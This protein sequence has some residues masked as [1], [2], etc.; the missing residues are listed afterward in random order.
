M[1]ILA[2]MQK[3]LLLIAVGIGAL[4]II[5]VAGFFLLNKSSQSN[6]EKTAVQDAQQE[7]SQ[8][9]SSIQKLL[10]AGKNETCSVKYPA[11]EQT[12][13]GT[14][15][16]NGKNLRGDFTTTS[17]GK[18]IDSHIIQDETYMYSWTSLAPQGT[19]MKIAELEKLQASPATESVDL[20]QEFDINC[21]S[22][23][24]DIGKFTPPA[25]VNFVEID[26]TPAQTQQPDKSI[27]DQITDPQAKTSCL[28]SL[29]RN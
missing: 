24:V 4:V 27:C 28:Q 7:Q 23:S 3:Q 17:E 5:G 18:T 22:W 26:T 16:V 1:C 6:K 20:N 10:A 9:K 13:D 12:A 11:G 21:S 15:Y 8:T 29:G 14:I 25:N 2:E 19:K